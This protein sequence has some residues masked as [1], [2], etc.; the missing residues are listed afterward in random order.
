MANKKT[1]RA[2]RG[3]VDA[4]GEAGTA[5]S[6]SKPPPTAGKKGAARARSNASRPETS[7]AKTSAADKISSTKA[8][9]GAF[10]KSLGPTKSGKFAARGAAPA[11]GATKGAV[12]RKDREADVVVRSFE[13]DRGVAV[14]EF[15]RRRE[16][17]TRER[18]PGQVV[19]M[20]DYLRARRGFSSDQ[21]M[22]E[23]LQVHRTRL[24]AWKQGAEV[25][26]AQNA[27]LLS[28][29]A[30]VVNELEEFLD[31]DVIPDWLVTEQYALGGETP[32]DAL[33]EGHLAEVLQAAN[34]TEHG[35]Y[36]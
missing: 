9:A 28:Y 35:S 22:A 21:E 15:K 6:S 36:V 5:G 19:A 2:T 7:T 34:A 25:P 12:R 4:T 26:N 18:S 20:A 17:Y 8:K 3:K 32:V 14:L 11:S 29:L 23:L 1:S 16:R 24:A 33:R 27:Q 30:V 10:G 31:P 13:P